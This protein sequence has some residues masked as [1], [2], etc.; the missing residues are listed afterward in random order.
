MKATDGRRAKRAADNLRA[1][2][3]EALRR[4]IQDPR[5]AAL[6]VTGVA[7]GD[8]LALARVSV[9]LLVGDDD[10]RRRSAALACLQSAARRLRRE[11]APKLAMRRMP[12]LRFEY[13]A[14]HDAERRVHDLL[15]EIARER[16]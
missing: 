14:G 7:L 13:D 2:L 9:R 5:L 8:D 16:R 10:A 4:D 12:E 1:L 11:L 15:D 3:V 6:V